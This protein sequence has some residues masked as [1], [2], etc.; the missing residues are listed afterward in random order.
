MLMGSAGK[1]IRQVVMHIDSDVIKPIVE[2]QYVYNMRYD[3]D[4]NIKGDLQIMPRGAINLANRETMN[5][6]RIEFLNATANQADM[7]IMGPEGR[8]ALLREVAKSLQMPTEDIIPSRETVALMQRPSK[9]QPPQGGGKPTPTQ[10][11]GSPK[12]GQQANVVSSNASG[13]A[14]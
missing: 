6:R 11:D 3:D 13:G 14:P 2:R 9:G 5:V 4:E 12:G 1:G 8:A 7:E 10:P